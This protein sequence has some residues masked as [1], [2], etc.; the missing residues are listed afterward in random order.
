[1]IAMA[2]NTWGSP[3]Q[4]PLS[5][6]MVTAAGFAGMPQ[7]GRLLPSEGLTVTRFQTFPNPAL[8]LTF[9]RLTASAAGQ[10]AT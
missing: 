7:L 6:A 10:R 4:L 8:N 3:Y 5:E 1:M 2:E 9:G